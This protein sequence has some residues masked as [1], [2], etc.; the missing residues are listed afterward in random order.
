VYV[1]GGVGTDH[2]AL[3]HQRHVVAIVVTGS[4]L[5]GKLGDRGVDHS[6]LIGSGVGV[7]VARP[8]HTGEC[9]PVIGEA[10]HRVEPEPALEMCRRLFLVVRV[11]LDQRRVHVQQ[12]RATTTA[13]RP[14]PR[15]S[16]RSRGMQRVEHVGVDRVEGAPDRWR[17][18]HCA[19]QVR[20][21]AQRRHVG[22]TMPAIGKHRRH[23]HEQT[24]TV[25]NRSTL[26][27]PRHRRRHRR[28]E[29]EPIGQL[30]NR[31]RADVTS[32]LTIPADHPHAFDAACN[33]H[34]ASA[35]PI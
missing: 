28:S 32:H 30:T 8:Q 15:S 4:D 11:N 26:T 24:T 1:T 13:A 20:L 27:G 6:E 12:Q 21:V 16:D 35:L 9:V 10:E 14:Y 22:D 25:M 18:R 2:D 19:E 3:T 29:T 31:M 7:G 23:L 33:L 34:H 5:A 17:R